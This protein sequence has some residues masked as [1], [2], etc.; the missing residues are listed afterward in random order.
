MILSPSKLTP[1]TTAVP[2]QLQ[3]TAMFCLVV[4]MMVQIVTSTKNQINQAALEI[5]EYQ[6]AEV[7]QPVVVVAEAGAEA[8]SS[9]ER[10]I[11][12]LLKITHM[13]A[14]VQQNLFRGLAAI[15]YEEEKKPAPRKVNLGR[16]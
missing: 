13:R 7:A 5:V 15:Q 1:H 6:R 10:E 4:V 3:E 2:Q 12:S 14:I 11:V 16:R 9:E 8:M